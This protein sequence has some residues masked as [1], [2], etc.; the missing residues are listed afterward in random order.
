MGQSQ[1]NPAEVQETE[2]KITDE[3]ALNPADRRALLK[4]IEQQ[5]KGVDVSDIKA[6]ASETRVKLNDLDGDGIPEV[7]AQGS[8]PA[9][10]ANGDCA[11]WQICSPTGNC[12]FW[13]F[14]KKKLGYVV[15]LSRGAVQNFTVQ[16]TRKN[17]Y[18]DLVLGM[19]GSA[20]E[21]DLRLYQFRGGRYRNVGCYNASWSYIDKN[22]EERD[23]KIP[24][25]TP[26]QG[27][28]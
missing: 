19:H 23:L 10:S 6:L 4:L 8:G 22:G 15:I 16:R 17:R 20:R 5:L 7:I 2:H 21:Q 12:P 9:C 14:K 13:I 24:R 26:C 1:W 3:T 28:R 27:Y 18:R 11:T 25:V